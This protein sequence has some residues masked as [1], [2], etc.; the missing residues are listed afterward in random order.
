[1]KIQILQSAINDLHAGR[2]FYNRQ[3]DGVGEYFVSSLFSDIDSLTLFA[4]V[5]HFLKNS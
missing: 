1:M 5:H 3:Q 4:W 2:L